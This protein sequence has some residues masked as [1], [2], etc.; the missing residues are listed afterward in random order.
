MNHQEKL[1]T[2]LIELHC[3]IAALDKVEKMEKDPEKRKQYADEVLRLH[4]LAK[5][6]VE[7]AEAMVEG[8]PIEW[9]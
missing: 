5:G 1:Q 6:V 2:L 8:R 4:A 3:A 9:N 7:D